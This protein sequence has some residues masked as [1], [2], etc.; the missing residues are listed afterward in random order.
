MTIQTRTQA[1]PIA[2]LHEHNAFVYCPICTHTVEG[3]VVTEGKTAKVKPGQ[4]CSRC[5]A[6]L[7]PAY[8]MRMDRAA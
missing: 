1:Q 8:I 3:I 5:S 2:A 4:K 6:A 7:D